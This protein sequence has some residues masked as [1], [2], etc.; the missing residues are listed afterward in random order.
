MAMDRILRSTNDHLN[1]LFDERAEELKVTWLPTSNA[2][3]FGQHRRS[4]SLPGYVEQIQ[5]GR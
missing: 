5:T 3:T 2:D 4:G 1:L